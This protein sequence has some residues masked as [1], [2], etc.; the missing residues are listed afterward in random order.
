MTQIHT[1]CRNEEIVAYLDGELEGLSLTRLERHLEDCSH[2]AGELLRQRRLLQ[3]VNTALMDEPTIEVPKEFA[4]LVAARAQSDMSGMRH[5]RE[6]LRA[7][8]LTAGLVAVALLVVGGTA[9]RESILEPLRSI[10]KVGVALLGFF[11]QAL[12]DGG[13]SVA[14]ISRGIGAHLLFESRVRSLLFL[15]LLALALFTLTRLIIRYHRK[16]IID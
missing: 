8:G 15:V 13:A 2:C 14:V 7:L 1:T 5:R 10:W 11:G 9:L 4:R 3:H 6:G 16:R 12:Y